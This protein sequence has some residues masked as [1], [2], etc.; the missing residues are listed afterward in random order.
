MVKGSTI[1]EVAQTA[2]VDPVN[3]QK[4][5]DAYNAAREAGE[6]GE[7]G[8][9]AEYLDKP[10]GEGP[11]YMI[12]IIPACSDTLGGVK[13]NSSRQVLREDG[14]VIEGLYAVGAMSNK[15]YY[16]QLYF[17]GSA[18]TFSSTDG[19][20]AGA[21]CGGCG[22]SHELQAGGVIPPHL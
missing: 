12:Q 7:F 6:D 21:P 3:L 1:E 18:L 4:S 14:S 16:N 11:Y 17:S 20:I 13:T 22:G 10:I 2:G 9:S 19:R 5:V 8:K 15:Y